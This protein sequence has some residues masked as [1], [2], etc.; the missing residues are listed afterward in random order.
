MSDLTYRLVETPHDIAAYKRAYEEVWRQGQPFAEGELDPGD[1]ALR[2]LAS[3][4]DEVIGGFKV[5]DYLVHRNQTELRCAGVASVAI[6]PQYR[7]SGYGADMMRWSLR[8]LKQQGFA[9]AALYPFRGTYYRK[10]GYEFCGTRWQIKCPM[11]RFPRFTEELPARRIAV[12]DVAQLDDCY[13]QFISGING[14]NIRTPGQWT[15]RMGKGSPLIYAVGD[16]IEAYAWSSMEGGFWEDLNIGEIAWSTPRG[17]ESLM[18]FLRGL[19]INRGALVW[20]EPA[21]GPFLCRFLDQGADITLHRPAMYRLLDVPKVLELT[22]SAADDMI[23]VEVQDP[24]LPENTGRWIWNL[25]PEGT[26]V[27]QTTDEPDVSGSIGAF[28][29]AYFG[30]PSLSRLWEAGAIEVND[31]DRV[32]YLFPST[33]VMCTEFF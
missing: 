3:L 33:P 16:P 29:Q 2:Y 27:Q 15:Q 4:G 25:G 8:E 20:N 12:E 31:L 5:H 1:G 14:A 22:K 30:E 9:V 24:D 18:A 6:R 13:Q 17:Y 28:T 23:V 19:A 26:V 11:S 32:A 10:F 21:E 7:S